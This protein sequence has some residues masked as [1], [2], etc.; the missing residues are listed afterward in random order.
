MHRRKRMTL[1][2]GKVS[3]D[4]GQLF[5][6]GARMLLNTKGALEEKTLANNTKPQESL[7]RIHTL[8]EI[9]ISLLTSIY[10]KSRA[11]WSIYY[12]SRC[13]KTRFY[14]LPFL[15]VSR[16]STCSS[17]FQK[18]LSGNADLMLSRK[19]IHSSCISIHQRCRASLRLAVTQGQ[20]VIFLINAPSKKV[21]CHPS[22]DI[23]QKPTL[24]CST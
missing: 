22:L 23:Y 21:I 8:L 3:A 6:Y 9:S 13:L 5:S 11:H 12:I 1:W 20:A 16:L 2:W 10:W 14:F 7:I 18:V 17:S 4:W 19:F 15:W 24:L